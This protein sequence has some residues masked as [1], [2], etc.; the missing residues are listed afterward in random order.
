MASK[1]GNITFYADDPQRLALFWGG[2][3]G[4]P[5]AEWDEPLKSEL[6]AAGLTE[7]DLSRRGLAE[8]PEGLGPRLFFH[9][10]SESR[11]RVATGCTSTSRRR[12]ESTL[13]ARSS[14]PRRIGSSRWA[15][16]SC[17]WSTRRGAHGGALLTSC[18]TPKETNSAFSDEVPTAAAAPRSPSGSPTARASVAGSQHPRRHGR[19]GPSRW[20]RPRPGA[21]CRA[22]TSRSCCRVARFR[23]P[24]RA[25]RESSPTR[26]TRTTT[27]RTGRSAGR[28]AD[29]GPPAPIIHALTAVSIAS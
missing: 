14:R 1:L 29:R 10:A 2:V 6:L 11:S 22:P 7:D 17:D 3:F 25:P 27:P 12:P 15:P 19:T 5:P 16:R 8:D 26:G 24:P 20:D 23:C 28:P 18:A 13:H 21:G 4:Y 9:H